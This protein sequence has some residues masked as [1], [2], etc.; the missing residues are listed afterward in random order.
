[1][2]N[3]EMKYKYAKLTRTILGTIDN[4]AK[5]CFDRILCNLAMMVSRYHGIPINYCKME[6]NTSKNTKFKLQTALGESFTSYQNSTTTPIH[7][8][9][10]GSCASPAIWLMVSSFLNDNIT[11]ENIRYVHVRRRETQ[12]DS[13]TINQR[14]FR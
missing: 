12:E 5:S 14:I 4:D 2:L 8:T 10:Q 6:G 3:K 11:T 1:V 7:G 13:T 9:G